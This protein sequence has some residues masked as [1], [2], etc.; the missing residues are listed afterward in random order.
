MLSPSTATGAMHLHRRRRG[1]VTSIDGVGALPPPSTKSGEVEWSLQR[2]SGGG[3]C[4]ASVFVMH[5][6][7]RPPSRTRLLPVRPPPASLG[8]VTRAAVRQTVP[9]QQYRSLSPPSTAMGRCYLNGVGALPPPST[10]SGE[11]EWSL[12]R[13]SGGGT[14]SASVFVMHGRGRTPSRTRLLPVRPPPASR[15][16][17]TRA[18]D[19][20]ITRSLDYQMFSHV[21]H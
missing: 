13:H 1:V 14:C 16:E 11:V 5:G 21:L 2:H 12:Q 8:E 17:V 15:G 20:Q 9:R 10:E 7:G 6:R 19:C 18:A 3:T 4:S